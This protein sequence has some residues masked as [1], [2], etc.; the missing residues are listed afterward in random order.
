VNYGNLMTLFIERLKE[1]ARA[2]DRG[3]ALGIEAEPEK[4][5]MAT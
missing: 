4:P 2:A 1:L 5:A 3:L